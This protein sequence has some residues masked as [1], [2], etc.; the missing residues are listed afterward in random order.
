MEIKIMKNLVNSVKKTSRASPIL[1]S[2]ALGLAWPLNTLGLFIN[3]GGK[4]EVRTS[5]GQYSGVAISEREL[6]NKTQGVKLLKLGKDSPEDVISKLGEP[7]NRARQG[8]LAEIWNYKYVVD[9]ES[10]DRF[11]VNILVRFASNGLLG[12][13]T[14]D[15][16]KENQLETLYTQSI[17]SENTA[18]SNAASEVL[19]TYP[20]APP[21]PRPGQMYFNTSDRHFYGWNGSAWVR[22]DLGGQMFL[23]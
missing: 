14:L 22:L 4:V 9:F 17:P 2:L 6:E 11:Q 20:I 13:V 8:G 18:Q 1:I 15:K 12:E 7:E 3:T 21:D 16:I 23:K 5:A 10:D 19:K